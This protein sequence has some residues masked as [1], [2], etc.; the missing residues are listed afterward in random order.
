MPENTNIFPESQ[1]CFIALLVL[2]SEA[3]N[4][5]TQHSTVCDIMKI[6]SLNTADLYNCLHLHNLLV[7]TAALQKVH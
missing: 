4:F 7:S 1:M 5:T 3:I 2:R 6:N